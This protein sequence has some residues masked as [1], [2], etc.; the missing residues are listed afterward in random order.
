MVNALSPFTP[1]S[2]LMRRNGLSNID[3][4][5]GMGG[6]EG[7]RSVHGNFAKRCVGRRSETIPILIDQCHIDR[8][9]I[10]YL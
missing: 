3:F 4:L 1:I 5:G 9:I 10:L 8:C 6:I 7:E 2:M